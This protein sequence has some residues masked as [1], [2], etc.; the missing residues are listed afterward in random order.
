LSLLEREFSIKAE[1]MVAFGDT[2]TTLGIFTNVAF[3][4]ADFIL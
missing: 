1:F 3:K 4:E 2:I